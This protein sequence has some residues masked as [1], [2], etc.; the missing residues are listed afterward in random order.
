M[1]T[2]R[3]SQH[4]HP[5]GRRDLGFSLSACSPTVGNPE[6]CHFLQFSSSSSDGRSC[7]GYHATHGKR[8]YCVQCSGMRWKQCICVFMCAYIFVQREIVSRA[9]FWA[10]RCKICARTSWQASVCL[11][12]PDISIDILSIFR[13]KKPS[14]ARNQAHVDSSEPCTCEL[15]KNRCVLEVLGLVF[16]KTNP[17]KLPRIGVGLDCFRLFGEPKLEDTFCVARCGPFG[18]QGTTALR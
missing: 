12:L 5:V 8:Y 2:H 9:G 1:Y 15:L 4:V 11:V 16:F 6:S 17:E 3:N 10:E 7:H 14:D 13:I 18:A